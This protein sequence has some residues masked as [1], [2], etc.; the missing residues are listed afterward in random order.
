MTLLKN[1]GGLGFNI[2]GGEDNEPIYVSHLLPN[3]VA[4]FSG[5]VK[6]VIF[7]IFNF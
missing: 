1:D 3:G 6:K 4:D 7:L 2:V 5:S